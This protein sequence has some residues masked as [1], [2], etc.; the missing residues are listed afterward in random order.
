VGYGI[1]R[2]NVSRSPLSWG[3]TAGLDFGLVVLAA[4]FGDDVAKMAQ[5]AMEYDLRPPFDAGSPEKGK[6]Q[7]VDMVGGSTSRSND[8]M[9]RVVTQLAQRGWG[10]GRKAPIA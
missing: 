7:L 8:D 10:R 4:M 9:T 3:V 5:L 1:F 2:R 6:P